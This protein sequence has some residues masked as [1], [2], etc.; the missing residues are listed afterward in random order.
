M[1][2]NS[3][4]FNPYFTADE[5]TV[6]PLRFFGLHAALATRE[7]PATSMLRSFRSETAAWVYHGACI[8]L[9]ASVIGDWAPTALDEKHR[10]R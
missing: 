10:S 3:H 9:D 5:T 7:S 8:F 2:E 6:E 1:Q 4:P